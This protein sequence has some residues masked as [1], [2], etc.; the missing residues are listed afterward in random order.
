[1]VITDSAL[2]VLCDIGAYTCAFTDMKFVGSLIVLIYS[3]LV[4]S[5]TCGG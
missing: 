3:M 4:F 1:M 2:F 5:Q